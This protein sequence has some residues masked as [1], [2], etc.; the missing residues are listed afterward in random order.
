MSL[1]S[2]ISRTKMYKAEVDFP[3]DDDEDETA[4]SDEDSY[5]QTY[6]QKEH[7]RMLT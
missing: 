7:L 1:F 5:M 4:V 2:G 3:V 6:M